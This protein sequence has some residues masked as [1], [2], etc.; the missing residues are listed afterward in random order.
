MFDLSATQDQ[1]NLAPWRYDNP[2][3]WQQQKPWKIG[4]SKK[5][6]DCNIF[7]AIQFQVLLLLLLVSGKG[8]VI[9][10][11]ACHNL[12]WESEGLGWDPL[13]KM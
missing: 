7:Q 11:N 3:N 5:G 2:W 1:W 9:P 4:H 6:H 13:H 8:A 12:G 10:Y